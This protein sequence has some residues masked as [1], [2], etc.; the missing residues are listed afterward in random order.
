MIYISCDSLFTILK[1]DLSLK[2]TLISFTATR[3]VKLIRAEICI[4]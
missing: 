1:E 4:K 3:D 2:S